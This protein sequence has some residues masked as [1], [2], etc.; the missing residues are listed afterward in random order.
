MGE[1]PDPAS[2]CQYF[3]GGKSCRKRSGRGGCKRGAGCKFRHVRLNE[4]GEI[5][6]EWETRHKVT[7]VSRLTAKERSDTWV[8]RAGLRRLGH[9]VT[10]VCL[11]HGGLLCAGPAFAIRLA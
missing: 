4:K 3:Q 5:E 8:K 7:V 2:L 1:R 9:S 11:L 6:K 10:F